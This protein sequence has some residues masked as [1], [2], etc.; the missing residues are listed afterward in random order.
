MKRSSRG[1]SLVELLVTIGIIGILLAILLPAIGAA[2]KQAASIVCSSTLRQMTAAAQMCAQQHHGYLPLAG[3]LVVTPAPGFGLE[4]YPIGLNDSQ[5]QRYSYAACTRIGGNYIP[6]PITAALAP[7]M[8]I[9]DLPM[10]SWDD[11]DQALNRPDVTRHF[12]CPA[13]ESFNKERASDNPDD[14]T[15]V[16]QG[17]MMSL[18]M[19]PGYA[20]VVWSTNSDYGI[21]EGVF[22]FNENAQY[23]TRRMGGNI[24]RLT[25]PDQLVL[26]TDANVRKS[27]AYMW[28]RDPWICWTPSLEGSGPVTLADALDDN[29]KALDSAM[30]DM[31]RHK[32]RIN[33]AF[34][35]G[36]VESLRINSSDLRSAFLL[37]R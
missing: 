20:S 10:E 3:E 23:T 8:G 35:D 18:A 34:A 7:F 30:F 17:M 12:A 1:F 13:S 4:A 21:N 25:K 14:L 36:H 2:R 22:G 29:G 11:L 9:N 26:F 28:F 32:G 5:R 27:L 6:I 15:L 31:N 24:G 37:P 33:V 19:L 16:G